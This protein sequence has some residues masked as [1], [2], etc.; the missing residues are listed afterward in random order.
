MKRGIPYEQA[1][2]YRKIFNSD[3][4]FEER[5][6]DLEGY[7]IKRGFK[8]SSIC[9]QFCKAKGKRRENLLSQGVNSKKEFDPII[10]VINFH[11]A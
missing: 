5:L 8:K 1:L 7:F 10:L 3:D 2:G 11:P 9:L 4:V 6:K